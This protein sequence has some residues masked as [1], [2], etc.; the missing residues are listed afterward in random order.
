MGKSIRYAE[1]LFIEGNRLMTAGDAR[2]AMAC[3]RELIG[4]LPD[5]AE[6]HAK[7]GL[8]L[9]QEGMPAE[10]EHHYRHAI[11]LNPDQGETHLNLG[12]LL[13]NQKRFEEAEAHYR[14]ALELIPDSPAA[15]SNLGVLQACLKQE[16]EA[17][18]S[19]RIAM[20]I[21][22][23]HRLAYFNLSYLLL[24]QGRFEEGWRC[25]ETRNWYEQLE[26][27]IPCPR[28]RGESLQGLSLLISFEAGHGDM[29]QFCRYAKVTES[30]GGCT[31]H[32]GL[33][34][35]IENP[36]NCPGWCGYRSCL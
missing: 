18:L 23:D 25:L 9:D 32:P 8:L 14:R 33:P 2:E 6:A 27:N 24:R 1:D 29:I 21:D 20:A 17:E 16:K 34:S 13:A 28:W 36:V 15:W 12:V 30:P 5:F 35:G 31:N 4:L 26:K 19:Y 7:L 10:A 22:P 3:F 11:T